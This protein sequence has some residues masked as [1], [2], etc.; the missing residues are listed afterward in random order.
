MFFYIESQEQIKPMMN[1]FC[2]YKYH[3]EHGIG[4]QL[5]TMKQRSDNCC[6]GIPNFETWIKL[7]VMVLYYIFFTSR[8]GTRGVILSINIFHNLLEFVHDRSL[9]YIYVFDTYLILQIKTCL[10]ML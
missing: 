6:T 10:H 9:Y 8:C 5:K 3:V 7:S 1:T 4:Y 2:S